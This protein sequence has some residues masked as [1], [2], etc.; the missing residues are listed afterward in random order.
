MPALLLLNADQNP[1]KTID[2]ETYLELLNHNITDQEHIKFIKRKHSEDA[3]K[4]NALLNKVGMKYDQLIEQL[5]KKID[6]QNELKAVSSLNNG[7]GAEAG[8]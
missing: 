7:I 1:L 4:L 2:N 6:Q 8:A 3:E 5:E